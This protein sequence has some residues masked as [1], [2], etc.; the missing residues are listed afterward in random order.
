[1]MTDLIAAIIIVTI[2]IGGM[3]YAHNDKAPEYIA[4]PTEFV[5]KSEGNKECLYP[6]YR[7]PIGYKK[8]EPYC[9]SK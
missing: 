6:K 4:V 2:G 9:R 3:L 7:L 5:V 8:Y 1:M